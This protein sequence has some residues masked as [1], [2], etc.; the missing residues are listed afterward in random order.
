[1]LV[2]ID[3]FVASYGGRLLLFDGMSGDIRTIKLRKKK[4]DCPVCG[5][6]PTITKLIDYELFCG[7]CA[8]DKVRF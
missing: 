7:S 3:C 6:Q 5:N 4:E 8:T 2:F 1:M